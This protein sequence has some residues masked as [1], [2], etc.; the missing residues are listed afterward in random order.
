L[1][2]QARFDLPLD[3]P[4]AYAGLAGVVLKRD[5]SVIVGGVPRKPN[6]YGG[7]RYKN[8]KWTLNGSPTSADA[9]YYIEGDLDI[10]G[11]PQFAATLLVEGSVDMTG[12]PTTTARSDLSPKLQNVA[13]YAG[14]DIRLSGTVCIDGVIVAREQVSMMGNVTV[15]GSVIAVDAQDKSPLVTTTSDMNDELGGGVSVQF[16]GP[17]GTFLKV[18]RDT[19]DLVWERRR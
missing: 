19:L 3:P 8:G 10:S 15:R 13:I 1:G 4:S 11:H 17:L 12:S 5:G 7:F 16:P 18:P 6:D 9:V 14:G 2:G